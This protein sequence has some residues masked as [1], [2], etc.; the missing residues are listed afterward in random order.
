MHI[1]LFLIVTDKIRRFG[2]SKLS[3]YC[4]KNIKNIPECKNGAILF[5]LLCIL[6]FCE[7][8]MY[9]FV[10]CNLCI[11]LFFYMELFEYWI[12]IKTS[13]FNCNESKYCILE[14]EM[15]FGHEKP[16]SMFCTQ[17]QKIF[18]FWADVWLHNV[19]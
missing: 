8:L 4:R 10:F 19:A 14:L 11:L 9:F 16:F 17:I 7:F 3:W 2:A 15:E 13:D 18:N 6:L 1:F 5:Y 12:S